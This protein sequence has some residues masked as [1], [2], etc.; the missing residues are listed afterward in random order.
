MITTLKQLLHEDR[1][2]QCKL[3]A[4]ETRK[5]RKDQTELF[6]VMS[7]FEDIEKSN[8]FLRSGR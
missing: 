3:T 7:D 8:Y 5:I 2:K 1:L 4:S 6:K